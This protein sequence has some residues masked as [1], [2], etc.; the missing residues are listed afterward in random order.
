MA[1]FWDFLTGSDSKMKPFNKDSLSKLM[2]IIQGGGLNNNQTY[3]QGNDYLQGLLSNDP[4]AFK[5]FEAP[6]MQNFE[7]NIIPSIAERFAGM[8]TG[9]GAGSSSGLYSSLAQAGKNL[10]T[11]L[12][13]LRG[14]LQMQA[15]PQGLNYA[16]QPI[17]NSFNASNALP[18][19]Y[20][21]QP[22]QP[23]LFQQAGKAFGYGAGQGF[24]GGGNPFSNFLNSYNKFQGNPGGF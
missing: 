14:G 5:H 23:G 12:A 17:N 4:E 9:G 7:Q 13:G 19:Q 18:N 24:G 16:Q 21:E 3:N 1:N 11:D 6:Y 8:G 20:Y 2:E 10:Q 22:G 15:L